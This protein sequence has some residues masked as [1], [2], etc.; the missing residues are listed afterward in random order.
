M[1]IRVAVLGGGSW[2]TTVAHL[3]SHQVPTTLWSRR[4][5]PADEINSSHTNQR[6]LPGYRL[7]EALEATT[8][9]PTAVSRADVLVMGVPSQHFRS[10]LEE[11][12]PHVRAWVPVLS[13][14]KGLEQGTRQRMTEII[15]STLPGH[16]AA[17][18][19]GPNLAKEILTGDAAAAVI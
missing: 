11:A 7:H 13:L 14:S 19:T 1:N 9:L 3:A 2:G 17:V 6:Y 10:V 15:E 4:A 5:E 18:L 12:A 16:P 8:D